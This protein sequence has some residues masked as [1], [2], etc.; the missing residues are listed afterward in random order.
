MRKTR[1]GEEAPDN[2]AKPGS[3]GKQPIKK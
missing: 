1:G 2:L 3:V